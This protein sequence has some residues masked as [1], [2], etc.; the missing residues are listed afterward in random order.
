L[1]LLGEYAVLDGSP[2]LV[3][4]VSARAKVSIGSGD[5]RGWSVV[6]H[7]ADTRRVEFHPGEASGVALLDTVL[8]H[9]APEGDGFPPCEIQLNTATFFS[10]AS[11]RKLG[12]GSSAALLVALD[13]AVGAWQ[14]RPR[15]GIERL[16]A[17]GAMHDRFQGSQG[18]GGDL[19]ASLHGGVICYRT[20]GP[21]RAEI[22]SVALPD[23][24]RFACVST[25]QAASSPE[26]VALF[27]SW[28]AQ[29]PDLAAQR[30]SRLDAM[31][32]AGSEAVKAGDGEGFL[33]AVAAYGELLAELGQALGAPI[34]TPEHEQLKRL[35][36]RIAVTYKSSGAGGGDM[37]M[38]FAL[39]QQRL[40][41]F[42]GAC[43]ELGFEAVNLTID[44]AGLAVEVFPDD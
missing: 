19:A 38:A 35:A 3:A 2:A 44:P 6:S 28:Q 15:G 14:G 1:F 31:A 24:V 9:R 5:S 29:Q 22:G 23:S 11:S 27:R 36:E 33:A 39:D 12:L 40:A 42:V 13:A 26:F 30:M 17:L 37:G 21:G 32:R 10:R 4:A 8:E 43:R 7:Q 16:A 41:Q 20:Q 18:S 34:S 25:G